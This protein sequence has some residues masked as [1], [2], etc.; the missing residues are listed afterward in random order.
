MLSLYIAATQT[1][2]MFDP[3]LDN[4]E[5]AHANAM[6]AVHAKSKDYFTNVTLTGPNG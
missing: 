3:I 5:A 4:I 6:H 1:S 2:V